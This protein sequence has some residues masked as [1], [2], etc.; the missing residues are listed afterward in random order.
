M[1]SPADTRR[2]L[3]RGGALL[4]V[5]LAVLCVLFGRAAWRGVVLAVGAHALLVAGVLG[6]ATSP[7]V[8]AAPDPEPEP[9]APRRSVPRLSGPA[10]WVLLV[11]G[12]GV[13]LAALGLVYILPL[14]D[15]RPTVLAGLMVLVGLTGATAALLGRYARD[16]G[17][18]GLDAWCRGLAVSA[19]LAMGSLALRVA[20]SP[21]AEEPLSLAQ[22]ALVVGLSIEPL[23]RVLPS[24]WAWWNLR[25]GEAAH[26]GPAVARA[27]LTRALFA[28]ANPVASTFDL[29]ENTLGIDIRATWALA[30]VRRA[31]GPLFA[32]VAVLGWLTT[33]L[34]MVGPDE[35]GVRERFGRALP[36]D[37]L[38]PGIHVSLPWPVERIR[39]VSVHTVHT[40]PVGHE[41][42]AL[43]DELAAVLDPGD[44]D[45]Q[46]EEELLASQRE[47]GPESRLW[48]KQH[49]DQEY[50]LL[51][52]DGRDLVTIDAQVHYRIADP[53]AWL[54]GMQNPEAALRSAAYQAVMQQVIGLSLDEA[55]GQDYR[56]FTKATAER[57]Q[58]RAEAL[59]LGVEV[60]DVTLGALHPPVSVATDYQAV[61]S[62]QIARQTAVVEARAYRTAELGGARADAVRAV[63]L[64]EA[65]ASEREAAAAGEVAAFLGLRAQVRT[66]EALYRSRRRAEALESQLTDRPVVILDHRLEPAA[67][68]WLEPRER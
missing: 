33:G 43:P 28:R 34:A 59:E 14:A 42:E 11:S 37:L 39:L 4:L 17:P 10:A 16:G 56:S 47:E 58:A 55:L 57:L 31:T 49:A 15:P 6:A 5:V 26:L 32:G 67:T 62:A 35:L 66:D 8:E 40:L 63:A 41:E 51:L 30:F 38:Q 65:A 68:L 19:V 64:A 61:V 23:L 25:S 13:A 36:G 12:G 1:S 52:G 54:Y 44:G 53:R 27:W 2:R 60:V 3:L 45:G 50:T 22:F 20:G 24:L 21:L 48:A 18:A 46:E 9:G 29:L 7:V